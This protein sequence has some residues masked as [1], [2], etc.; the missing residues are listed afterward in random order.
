M[1][2]RRGRNRRGRWGVRYTMQPTAIRLILT[3]LVALAV[4]A[5]AAGGASPSADLPADADRPTRSLPPL[6]TV[7]AETPSGATGEVPAQLMAEIL[8]DAAE[9]SGTDTTDITVVRAEQ[10]TWNDGSLGCPEPGMG[11]TQALVEGYH[12]VL[13][14]SG[15]EY[16]YR[17]TESGSFH[18]CEEGGPPSGG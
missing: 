10:Q 9:R 8:A 15:E 1:R 6:A 4:V 12:V 11:Y 13:A 2:G 16:D 3:M 14:A 18:L 5:C 7:P 17:A